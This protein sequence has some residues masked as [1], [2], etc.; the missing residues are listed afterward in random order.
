VDVVVLARKGSGRDSIL[1]AN[2]QGKER[3]Q[4]LLNLVGVRLPQLDAEG[5]VVM[6]PEK[7]VEGKVVL[8]AQGQPVLVPVKVVYPGATLPPVGS[9]HF[10][11]IMNQ[12]TGIFV[13]SIYESGI[14]KVREL[15]AGGYLQGVTTDSLNDAISGGN[16]NRLLA[17]AGKF[18]RSIPG[19]FETYQLTVKDIMAGEKTMSISFFGG[20]GQAFAESFER[21]QATFKF[22]NIAICARMSPKMQATQLGDVSISY[23][24][25][26]VHFFWAQTSVNNR[27]QCMLDTK[28]AASGKE[29]SSQT[30]NAA[31]ASDL[32]QRGTQANY[33]R[34]MNAIK[35]GTANRQFANDTQRQAMI[36]S[37]IKLPAGQKIDTG[38][39]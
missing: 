31:N 5:N 27:T 6:A 28:Y 16:L 8:D 2:A 24:P 30:V 36:G 25:D 34:N 17:T 22:Q 23:Q 11:I 18:L 38:D 3:D 10:D 39:L 37:G 14:Q 19:I 35:Q 1:Q 12:P 13:E 9:K 29:Y 20:E 33:S 21:L 26:E 32:A 7:D 15:V 4:V